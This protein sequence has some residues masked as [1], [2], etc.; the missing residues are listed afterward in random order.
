MAAHLH[1]G[2]RQMSMATLEN[3][4]AT[5]VPAGQPDYSG[6]LSVR[7]CLTWPE[8]ERFRD[9]WE[10]L[11]AANSQCSIF[12]TPEWI[13]AWWQS[14][15][16][17]REFVG[18]LFQDSHGA[19]VGIAP[20]YIEPGS[21]LR[22]GMKVLRLAG[23]GS[24]DS[25][26][27]DFITAPGFEKAVAASFLDWSQE[28]STWDICSLE[29]LPPD[30][31]TA[32]HLLCGART[33]GISLFTEGL[34]H[35]YVDLP[36]TWDSYLQMLE[37]GFRPLLAR[38]PKRLRS[39]Y[40]VRV[41]RSEQSGQL[42]FHLQTLFTLHQMRWSGRGEPGA[43]SSPERRQ[44]YSAMARGFL[45]RGWLEFWLLTLDNE[46]VAA[47]F[48]FRYRDT[49]YLLQ[50]GFHPR[51]AEEKIGYALRAHVLQRA[52]ESGARRYDFLGGADAYKKKFGAREGSYLNLHLAS[53]SL[54]G[55]AVLAT[56][57]WIRHGKGWLKK[58][59]PRPALSLLRREGTKP[60]AS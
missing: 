2:Y 3:H 15:N 24:G 48:C 7:A 19:V 12:L 30:S 41:F 51:Y 38:Y 31:P 34:P 1:P 43:F 53:P 45:K 44:F 28:Q 20:F 25:D 16:Q 5:A 58:N 8:L 54:A 37:P 21:G 46:I 36:A 4:I 18:L 35:S 17:G 42:D 29:T 9:D 47:Q 59:L 23:A 56:E 14:F 11:L 57:N 27:L 32:Q 39:R 60:K 50:E 10:R 55:R 13:G 49:V 52:I 33:K 26:A 6:T 22:S 40:E